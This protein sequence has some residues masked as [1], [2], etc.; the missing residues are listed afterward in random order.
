MNKLSYE[1]DGSRFSTL[2]GFFEEISSV[3]IPG[4]DWGKNLDAFNDILRGGFGTPERGYV[5]KWKSSALSRD[6][7]G[8]PETV[9]QLER[10]LQYCHP[11]NRTYVSEDLAKAKNCIGPTVFDWLI[12]IISVHY[13]G[14]EESEDGI[15]L[16]LE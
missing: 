8:Y 14:G 1:I 9:R 6:R 5:L 7:L 2:E 11:S 10:R 4:A 13:A 16:V 15:E 3:L 12:E